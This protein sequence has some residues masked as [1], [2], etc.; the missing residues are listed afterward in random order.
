MIENKIQN[1]PD[2]EI[3]STLGTSTSRGFDN[4]IGLF[5]SGAINSIALFSRIKMSYR[6]TEH[7]PSN[8]NVT[9]NQY[10]DIDPRLLDYVKICLGKDVYTFEIK[11]KYI[12]DGSGYDY[13]QEKIY[14]K[15]QNG[16]TYDL[17]IDSKFGELDWDNVCMGVR[18]FISNACDGSQMYNG[19]YNNVK[20]ETVPTQGRMA[21]AK[22]GFIRVYIPLISDIE[23]YA[24]NELYKNFRCLLS[25]FNKNDTLILNRNDKKTYIYRKG[26]K[27]GEFSK[28]SLFHYNINDIKVNES[29]TIDSYTANDNAAEALRAS[30]IEN[31]SMFIR[32]VVINKNEDLFESNFSSYNINP[33]NS[34]DENIKNNWKNACENVF[35]DAV[36]TSSVLLAEMCKDRGHN[37]I[38]I[39]D[40]FE[41]VFTDNYVKTPTS[42]LNVD[43]I[44]GKQISPCNDNVKCTIDKIC[45]VIESNDMD[46]NKGRPNIK[47]YRQV[48]DEKGATL[49]Y[50][51]D[52]T[53]YIRED[54]SNDL[55]D[56]LTQTCIEELSHHYSGATDISR[57]LQTYAFRLIS[58]LIRTK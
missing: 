24:I 34:Y 57:D 19:T 23:E 9:K 25:T 14:M 28:P 3:L 48:T 38:L 8:K 20:I 44:E 50:Y 58:K 37:V 4:L 43:E 5:G 39:D 12:K 22:D 56:M 35:G 36:V 40:N 42:V 54:I 53:V 10:G 21:R 31:I 47:L 15:K 18:E 46:N 1:I 13:W 2:I 29:R 7:T 32:E 49:G 26:V 6:L 33:R 30:S 55:G 52:N 17:N 45:N 11:G 41:N 51:R 16:C 27:V